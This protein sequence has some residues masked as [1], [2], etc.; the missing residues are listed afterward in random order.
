MSSLLSL[1]DYSV[2]CAQGGA[3]GLAAAFEDAPDLV[4]SDVVMPDIDGFEVV[5]QLKASE[6]PY[7]TESKYGYFAVCH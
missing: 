6:T 2:R 7:R 4:L 3:A 5:R 1:S